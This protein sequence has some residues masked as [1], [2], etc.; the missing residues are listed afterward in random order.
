MI[1]IVI[2]NIVALIASLLMVYS[3]LIKQKKKILYVQTVQIGL[4]VISNII[5][6]GIVGAIINALS[7]VR[8]I[9]CYKD[10]L[11]IKE[12]IIITILALILSISFNNIGIIGILPLISTIV[13]LWLMN[14]ENVTKFK[15][16]IIFTMLLW[17][18]YDIYIKSYSSAVFDF[19]NI[20]A[21]IFSI[22]KMKKKKYKNY[23]K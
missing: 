12:R 1:Q 23:Q 10:K 22:L 8:N 18:I 6:G 21:N 16:L 9:L 13:Y 20:I 2:G 19:M 11:G 4:S 17:F 14:I 15:I 7:C 3:G 5:L